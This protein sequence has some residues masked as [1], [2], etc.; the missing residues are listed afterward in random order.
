MSSS[1]C[2]NGDEAATIALGQ[3]WRPVEV[4]PS[5]SPCVGAAARPG[6]IRSTG[7]GHG[8]IMGRQRAD[9]AD[10]AAAAGADA[11]G[12][13]AAVLLA[14]TAAGL[15]AGSVS[16][17]LWSSVGA[18]FVLSAR[19][20]QQSHGALS[21]N[22]SGE[23]SLKKAV[24]LSWSDHSADAST[25]NS[26]SSLDRK[27]GAKAQV[28]GPVSKAR[29]ILRRSA[30]AS[31]NDI[32]ER[33]IIKEALT[34]SKRRWGNCMMLPVMW[35]FFIFY[36]LAASI[37]E[38]PEQRHLVESPIREAAARTT[39]PRPPPCCRASPRCQRCGSS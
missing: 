8:H 18:V 19:E 16:F 1:G 12:S 34:E 35:F 11:V 21:A 32:I 6:V 27:A 31:T 24:S 23:G 36:A 20:R 17:D 38:D 3:H 28:V 25:A 5:V 30:L 33:K 26:A 10:D 15:Q 39:S 2:N 37:M 14:A 9:D 4:L 22:G 13:V 29:D 7:Q